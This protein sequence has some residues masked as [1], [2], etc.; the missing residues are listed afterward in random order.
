MLFESL[1][2]ALSRLLGF[3]G[4]IEVIGPRALRR[5]IRDY[6]EQVVSRYSV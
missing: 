1:E 2:E 3:G 4:A 6:A 5:S